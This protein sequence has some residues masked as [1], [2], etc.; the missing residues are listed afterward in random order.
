MSVVTYGYGPG[1]SP[2]SYGYG[3]SWLASLAKA[4]HL[5]FTFARRLVVFS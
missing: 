1:N 2:A 4:G 5:I 3:T